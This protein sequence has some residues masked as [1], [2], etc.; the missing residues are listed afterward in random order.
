MSKLS[1]LIWIARAQYWRSLFWN[2]LPS[3]LFR[4]PWLTLFDRRGSWQQLCE[5]LF[6]Y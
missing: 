2:S 1:Q 4:P 5:D 6:C 3:F